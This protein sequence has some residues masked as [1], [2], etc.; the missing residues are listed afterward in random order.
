MKDALWRITKKPRLSSKRLPSLIINA[1]TSIVRRIKKKADSNF[2][3]IELEK[4]PDIVAELGK[5]KGDR[6]VVG[7]AAETENLLEHAQEKLQKKNLDLIVAN[8]VSKAVS[9]SAL[10]R[11]R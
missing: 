9:V 5:I 4:N 11:T 10:T 2:M 7:F 3:T 8:N 6:I 1:G